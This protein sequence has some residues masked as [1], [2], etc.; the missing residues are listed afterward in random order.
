MGRG[1]PIGGYGKGT[2]AG[3]RQIDVRWMQRKGYLRPAMQSSLRWPRNGEPTGSI[4]YLVEQDRIVLSY[5]H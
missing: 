3:Y 1:G 5:R 4:H 2:S